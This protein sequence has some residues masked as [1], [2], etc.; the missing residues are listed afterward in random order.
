M[1]NSYARHMLLSRD[2]MEG[3]FLESIE[4]IE[5]SDIREAAGNFLAKND[6]VMVT[7][8]PSEDKK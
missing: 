6:Y 4:N 8:M 3:N 2:K 7:I 5:S 1:A